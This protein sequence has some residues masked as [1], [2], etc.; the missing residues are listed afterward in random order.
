MTQIR[1]KLI[2]L[3]LIAALL[4]VFIQLVEATTKNF[5]VERGQGETILIKLVAEDHVSIKFTVLGQ[6]EEKTLNFSI[7]DPHG[8]VIFERTNVGYVDYCFVCDEAGEYALHFSNHS[9]EDKQVTLNYEIQHYTF[10]IPQM[11]FLTIIIVF[12][13]IGAVATFV[14]IGKPR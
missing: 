8:N 6:T 14:L 4:L 13:C 5:T 2:R 12:V 1:R 7:I 11:L 9:T 10:G 3:S